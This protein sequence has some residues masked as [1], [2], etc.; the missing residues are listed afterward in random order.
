MFLH[1][2]PEA[3]DK[4]SFTRRVT[5]KNPT[6][7][8]PRKSDVEPG[9]N[10]TA[11]YETGTKPREPA[12]HGTAIRDVSWAVRGSPEELA[13]HDGTEPASHSHEGPATD[14]Q[15]KQAPEAPSSAKGTPI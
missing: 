9:W 14:E 3:Y 15:G 7:L 10:R 8:T 1:A 13:K 5:S 2:G 12:G 6:F 11:W 4:M